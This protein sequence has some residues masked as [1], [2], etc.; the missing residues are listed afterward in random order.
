MYCHVSWVVRDVQKEIALS[1]LS[2]I[3]LFYVV[4]VVLVLGDLHNECVSVVDQLIIIPDKYFI[5]LLNTA[6]LLLAK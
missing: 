4:F 1:W 6:L 2:R 3:M 5:T